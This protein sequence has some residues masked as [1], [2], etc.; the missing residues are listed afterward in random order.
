MMAADDKVVMLFPA[1][2]GNDAVVYLGF[3]QALSLMQHMHRY[4]IRHFKLR[5]SQGR[6]DHPAQTAAFIFPG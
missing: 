3:Q 6:A 2:P 1:I 4:G 5:A